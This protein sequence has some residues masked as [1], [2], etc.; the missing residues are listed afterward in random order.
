MIRGYRMAPVVYASSIA[1]AAWN[2][3]AGLV[4]CASLWV[5]RTRLCYEPPRVEVQ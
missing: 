3:V 4:L 1:V 5:V 2:A